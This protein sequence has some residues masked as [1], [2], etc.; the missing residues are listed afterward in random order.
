[1]TRLMGLQFKVIYRRGKE[2][3][4]ADALFRC[5]HLL[6]LQAVSEAQPV[7]IQEVLNTYA[8]DP[9]AQ[10]ILTRLAIKSPDDQGFSLQQGLIKFNNK[11]WIAE[12]SSL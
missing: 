8:I 1:M 7:W 3:L 2:N 4:A 11:V 10:E 6:A 9:Q 5:C 12:N